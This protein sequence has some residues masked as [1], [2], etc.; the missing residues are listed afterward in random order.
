MEMFNCHETGIY[1]ITNKVNGKVYIGKTLNF[2]KRKINYLSA[3]KHK[4][5]KQINHYFL[6]AFLKYGTE[7]FSF[8]VLE[9]CEVGDLS[10]RELYWMRHYQSTN[11]DKG[12]NLR[13][14]SSTGMICHQRT[15]DRLSKT[16]REQYET[17]VRSREEMSKRTS[18]M[19]KDEDRKQRMVENLR[20]AR[21][22][23]FVQKRRDDT[24]VNVWRDLHQLLYCNPTWKWQNV[25]A[26]CNGNKKTYFGYKWERHTE[27]PEGLEEYVRNDEY[28]F[29][30][31][32][33]KSKEN[34][35]KVR[36]YLVTDKK[37]KTEELG[38]ADFVAEYPCAPAKFSRLKSD[39]IEM[40]GKTIERVYNHGE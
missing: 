2:H 15:R 5:I 39:N 32:K 33:R 3:I 28:D 36:K 8:D 26:A 27:I 13:M 10:K 31:R 12:Y 25:Y 6:N 7:N 37:G 18:E 20:K 22:C 19:W 35:K 30:Y 4:R 16:I 17:G 14:D 21:A 1:I 38:W 11:R 40:Y 24:V 23:F 29:D 34:K 9:V